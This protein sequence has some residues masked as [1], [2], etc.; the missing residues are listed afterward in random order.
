[1]EN[2]DSARLNSD[3]EYRFAFLSKFL[4]FT[5]DDISVLNKIAPTLVPL[6]P[7]VVDAIYGNLFKFDTTTNIFATH[8][9]HFEGN[10]TSTP[11]GLDLTPERVTFL[12]DMLATYLKK[13]LTQTNYDKAF[14][15]YLSH[16]GKVHANKAETKNIDVSY[17]YM[18]ATLG[19]AAHVLVNALLTSDL[20]LDNATKNAAILALNKFVW[21]QNDFFTMHYIP[22]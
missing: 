4:N 13:A 3:V 21:I 7:T 2:L 19:F 11:G 1:M 6:V 12:K 18:N 16:L 10:S 20:G 8:K 14:L 9:V 22:K 17:V 15:E 5:K